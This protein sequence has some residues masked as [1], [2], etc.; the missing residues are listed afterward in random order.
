[1]KSKKT[2][3]NTLNNLI[4]RE[5]FLS[6]LA[7]KSKKINHAQDQLNQLKIPLFEH[8]KVLSYEN[9]NLLLGTESQSII[10]RF[11]MQRSEI[12]KQLRQQRE[13][14]DLLSINI[15]LFFEP[16]EKKEKL[17]PKKQIDIPN[18]ISIDASDKL[19]DVCKKTKKKKLKDALTKFLAKHGQFKNSP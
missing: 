5:N 4:K 9:S 14:C 3:L 11:H 16:M 10:A 8:I 7:Q 1:M 19:S 13:F 6:R 2:N 18:H 15:K 12:L 17:L